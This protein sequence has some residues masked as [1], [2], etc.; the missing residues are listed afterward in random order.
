MVSR[1]TAGDLQIIRR[2]AVFR[3][4]APEAVHR[5]IAR[6]TAMILKPHETVCRQG[7]A[8]AAF[9]IMIEGWTKHYRIN[10]SGEEAVIH[11]FTTGDSFAESAAL[12]GGQYPAPPRQSPMHASCGCPPTM[13]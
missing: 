8:A 3:G 11:L 12:T 1:L 2:I 5:I 6:A 13:S 10:V 4:L 9:F 7:D